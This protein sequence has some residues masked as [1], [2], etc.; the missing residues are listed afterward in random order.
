MIFHFLNGYKKTLTN[1]SE[2]VEK[3]E[4]FS[5]ADENVKWHS[6]WKTGWQILGKLNV[7]LPSDPA[8]PLL[9]MYPKN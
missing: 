8:I 4:P 7:D 2:D 5:L 3:L 6:L 9:D 1:V